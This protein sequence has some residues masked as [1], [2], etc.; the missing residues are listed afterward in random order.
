[1][2]YYDKSNFINCFYALNLSI[3][4]YFSNLLF[5]DSPNSGGLDRIIYSSNEFA[6][7]KR[8]GQT[9]SQTT[10]LKLPFMNYW[11]K[12]FDF[13]SRRSMFN[14]L[15]N[16]EGIY[17]ESLQKKLRVIP[18]NIK[19]EGTIFF[20]RTDDLYQAYSRIITE[21]SN[22][23][24][25]YS[26]PMINDVNSIPKEIPISAFLNFELGIDNKYRE[27]DWLQKNK[28]HTI[29]LNAFSFD[30]VIVSQSEENVSLTEE[31]IL[32]FLSTK[33]NYIGELDNKDNLSPQELITSYFT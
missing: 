15:A 3:E 8:I 23:T 27:T 9:G 30:T 10:D 22:E 4:N 26:K 12:D 6:F 33:P 28:I 18:V 20:N 31:V 19:Y 21:T 13:P 5:S 25:I 7:R 1:M 11:I 2:A 17:I 29:D 14:N 24:I 16:I 32:E